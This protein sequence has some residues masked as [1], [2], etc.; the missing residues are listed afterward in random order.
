VLLRPDGAEIE[1]AIER[2]IDSGSAG[3]F[4]LTNSRSLAPAAARDLALDLGEGIA[5]ASRAVGRAVSVVSRSDSTLRGHFPIEVDGLATGL[6][7]TAPRILLAPYFGEGGRVTVGDVHHLERNGRREPV[8]ATEFARDAA[9]G[10]RFSNLLEWVREKAPGRPVTS[11]GLGELRSTAGAA[12]AAGLAAAPADGVLVANAV[13]QRDIELVASG[14]LAAEATGLEV[15][16]RSAASY[17]RARL[18]QPV[19]PVLETFP[20]VAPGP[21]LVVVGSHVAV[22]TEQL[23]RLVDEPHLPMEPVELEVDRLLDVAAASGA[24]IEAARAADAAIGAGRTAV[25]HTSRVIHRGADLTAAIDIAQRVAAGVVDVVRRMERTPAWIVAKGGITSSDVAADALGARRAT[26]VG[27][28]VPG[29]SLWRIGP[30]SRFPALAFVVFPGNVG[31]PDA[32]RDVVGRL[33]SR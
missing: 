15:I 21:G 1:R 31:G 4:V 13:E 18:G 17:A 28:L 5:A 32:L 30:E 29:V 23:R 19:W 16:A 6:G 26:V 3:F 11:V 20:R 27:Q 33:A 14:V 7:M 2:A 8:A 25:I 22:T 9:F 10:Y 24:I 12:I